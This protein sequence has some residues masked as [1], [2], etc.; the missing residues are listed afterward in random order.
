[1][2]KDIKVMYTIGYGYVNL[3]LTNF[4]NKLIIMVC[5]YKFKNLMLNN[6]FYCLIL[7]ML[8]NFT[9]VLLCIP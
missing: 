8:R 1:M 4:V 3:M 6:K 5:V 2:F 9:M 7:H